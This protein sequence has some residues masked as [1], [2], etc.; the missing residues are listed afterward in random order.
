M[1]RLYRGI[2]CQKGEIVNCQMHVWFALEFSDPEFGGH[3]D[4]RFPLMTAS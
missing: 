3:P 4:S 2:F 1:H